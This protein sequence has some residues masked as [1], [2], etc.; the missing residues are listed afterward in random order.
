VSVST[1]HRGKIHHSFAFYP[2]HYSLLPPFLEAVKYLYLESPRIEDLHTYYRIKVCSQAA[3][4]DLLKVGQYG[5]LTWV[6]PFELLTTLE[7][8]RE[9]LRAF[10]DCEAYVGKAH[11]RV[12]SVNRQGLHNIG[13]LLGEFGIECK[14]YTYTRKQVTWNVNYILNISKIDSRRR[15]LK[16]IG[17]NHANKQEKLI[18]SVAE[19]GQRASLE[20]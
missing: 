15:F 14:F 13:A 6:V 1:D 7:L 3:C 19:S 9:W 16:E 18:A 10:F 17:F 8:K 4:L 20:N 12:Q 5:S 2:D 11:I